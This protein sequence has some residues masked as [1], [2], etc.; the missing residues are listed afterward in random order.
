VKTTYAR[1]EQFPSITLDTTEDHEEVITTFLE[2]TDDLDRLG[3]VLG[4]HLGPALDLA[5]AELK[6]LT[7]RANQP[8]RRAKRP[9]LSADHARSN[10]A[11]H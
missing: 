10:R 4:K 11:I 8:R 5:I 3:A 1:Y 6:T 9:I 7:E 2:A